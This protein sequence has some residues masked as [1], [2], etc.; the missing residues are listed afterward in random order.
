MIESFEI[1]RIL[2]TSCQL[3][4]LILMKIHNVFHTFLLR[5]N[6]NDSLSNQIAE[7]LSSI[8]AYED[9]EKEFKLNDVLNNRIFKKKLQYKVK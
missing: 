7:S 3:K 6:S 8:I 9:D 1:L 4:L 2:K 5:L